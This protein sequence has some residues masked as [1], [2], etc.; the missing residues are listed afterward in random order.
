M[1]KRAFG[2]LGGKIERIKASNVDP[3]WLAWELR[4]ARIIGFADEERA[5]NVHVNNAQRLAELVR[6]VQGNARRDV[7]QT[8]VSILLSQKQT[9]WLGKELKGTQYTPTEGLATSID[10]RTYCATSL[11]QGC[12]YC[13]YPKM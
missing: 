7:F 9:E 11:H 13:M 4:A 3:A 8:I 1:E 5:R 10:N 12:Y 6:V 2:V